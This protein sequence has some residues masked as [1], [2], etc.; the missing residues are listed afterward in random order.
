MVRSPEATRIS[1]TRVPYFLFFCSG[2]SGLI[3]QVAWVREFG[4]VFGNTVYSASLIVAIFMLGLGV[5]GYLVGIWADRRYLA[6]PESLL[7]AYGWAELAIAVLGIGIAA[8][9]PHLGQISA[10]VSSYSRD[11]GGWYTLST[12]SYVL[13]AA[14]A[15]VLLTPITIVMGG[16]LTLLIRH[17]VRR[18]FAIGARRTALL[19]GVNTMGAAV[20]SFATD[21]VLVP[22]AGL[23]VAQLVA[24]SMN[25]VAATGAFLLTARTGTVHAAPRAK[26]PAAAVAVVESE[27][28]AKTARAA[29]VLTSLA[30]ALTGFAAMGM[31]IV[32]LRHFSLLL[33]EFRAVFALLLT[34]ILVGIGVGAIAGGV[35]CRR[36]RRP[37]EWLMIAQGL[38]V[39]SV[40]LGLARADVQEI[41][42]AARGLESML[43]VQSAWVLSLAELWFNSKPI[44]SEV[45][46]PALLMGLAFPLGSAVVQCLERSVGRR[47]GVLYLWNTTGAVCGSL[48]AGFGL[49]PVVGIQHTA[50]IL[51]IAA[52][53]SI[54]PLY[55]VSRTGSVADS[56][57][58][59]SG[60]VPLLVSA[61]AAGFALVLW[62][63]LP[64]EYVVRR[65]QPLPTGEGRLLA[66]SEGVTEVI[67][68]TET[69]HSGRAL[70]TNGHPMTGTDPLGQRYMRALAHIPLLSLTRP[71]SVLVIGFGVGNTTHAATLH[72]SIRRVH[73]AD[74]SRH[75]LVHAG[76]FR[77][78][79]M[80]VLNDPRVSVYVN[81]G[82]QHLQMQPQASYDLITLEPP[83]IAQAGVGALYSRDFYALARTRLKQG[84]YISQWLPAYQVPGAATL[85]MIRAFVE[86]FPQAVLLSGAKADLLLV[87]ANDAPVEIDPERVASALA[88]APAVQA[89]LQRF[90]LGSV[91]EIVGTFMGSAQNL[92]DASRESP[93]VTDDRPM[94]EYSVRS[95]LNT[96]RR[97]EPPPASLL[98]LSQIPAWCPR[99][100]VNGKPVPLVEGIDTDL[101]LLH[102]FYTA[103]AADAADRPYGTRTINGSAYLGA[104]LPE[105]AD[106]HT[107]LGMGMMN[108]GQRDGAIAAFRDALRIDPASAA[109]HWHLGRALAS[110]GQDGAIDHLRRAVELEPR[111]SEARHDLATAL[112]EA[113]RYDEA[114]DHFRAALPSMPNAAVAYNS[115]GVGLVSRGKLAE[116]VDQFREAIRLR[117]AYAEAYNNLGTAL[118]FQ[119]KREEAV[120]QFRQALSLQPGY[121]EASRNLAIVQRGAVPSAFDVNGGFTTSR[122]DASPLH[123][124]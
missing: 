108:R 57:S 13:R 51:S 47:A 80:D 38:F 36:T 76:Y 25:I 6:Q 33:G 11:A 53:L 91:R 110:S 114:I 72:P 14:I 112:L 85:A 17:L 121:A 61:L 78:A 40:L 12:S 64:P 62:L 31:E 54:L 63:Q 97:S 2:M 79:N 29:L 9:L 1:T 58:S 111:N 115:L 68:V 93:P 106:V 45:A 83:P 90:A 103:P 5:G 49:L 117:P 74:L 50:T 24:V 86:I 120:A 118:A 37:A 75:I 8:L 119:G 34:V 48:A 123:R 94:Q 105:S 77:D 84:G 27:P 101:A 88:S 56:R 99:C 102:Q 41:H 10:A 122:P 35:L 4:N 44:L 7:R 104:I 67:A 95:L 16:T 82:R 46:V 22:L 15:V 20:G 32:W 98:D 23:Q 71:E 107:I 92:V 26:R 42:D 43:R 96:G 59:G 30:L 113:G 28:T 55:L 66:L 124:H 21:F 73:V 89:D 116:A 65:S 3:Y 60:T 87:G 70:W 39:A 109:A 52:G 100:F 69:P 19:Y 18:D 81:D